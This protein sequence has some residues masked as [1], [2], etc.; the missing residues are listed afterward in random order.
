MSARA[1]FDKLVA[2]P[3]INAPKNIKKPSKN[4]QPH[5][6]NQVCNASKAVQET[7]FAASTI[8]HNSG[9]KRTPSPESRERFN[10][11]VAIPFIG[12][13]TGSGEQRKNVHMISLAKLS[14]DSETASKYAPSPL[15][16]QQG[17]DDM[18]ETST[19]WFAKTT[20]SQDELEAN[21][22]T[23]LYGQ[24]YLSPVPGQTSKVSSGMP[25]A[26]NH[27]YGAPRPRPGQPLREW[28][29]RATQPAPPKDALRKGEPAAMDLEFHFVKSAG[30][31]KFHHVAGEVAIVNTAL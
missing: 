3:R 20:G 25:S 7:T 5:P 17:S 16:I 21:G 26:N 1:R 9:V 10:K 14:D 29:S 4:T 30:D 11:L 8:S 28:K 2:I 15:D 13:T 22:D 6:S 31:A 27:R 19:S 18:L 24:G 23:D 12:S